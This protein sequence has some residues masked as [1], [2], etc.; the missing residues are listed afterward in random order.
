MAQQPV[1]QPFQ[2]REHAHSRC[3]EQAIRTAEVTCRQGGVRLTE[4]RRRVLEFVWSSHE[5][6][7]AYDILE[8]LRGERRRAEPPT[9][10][11]ALEFLRRN[12]FV[13]RIESMNAYVGCGAPGHAGGGQFLICRDCGEVAEL[14]DADI[15]GL[16]S[17]KALALGFV[18]ELQTVELRGRCEAC[19]ARPA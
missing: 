2:R 9:V 5:P 14:G 15:A 17:A 19:R 12:K 3:L 8:R 18:D 1:L 4:L 6:V 16:L 10:Y 11:R 7:K 13:H